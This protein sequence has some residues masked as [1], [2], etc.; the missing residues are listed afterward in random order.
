[1]LLFDQSVIFFSVSVVSDLDF[2]RK[3]SVLGMDEQVNG[4]DKATV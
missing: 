1:M 3:G 4:C 2:E